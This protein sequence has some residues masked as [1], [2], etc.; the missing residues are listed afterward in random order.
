[1][2]NNPGSKSGAISLRL[3]AAFLFCA[4]A[5]LLAMSGF[6]DIPAAGTLTNKSGPLTYTAGPF[7]VSNK[8]PIIEVDV[9]PRCNGTTLPCDDHAL[10]V[11]LPSGYM[12][13]HPNAAVRVTMSWIDA[14][15]GQ[16]DYDMWVY[17][18][19]D[20]ACNPTDCSST[21]GT[22][23]PIHQSTT[24]ANP[25]VVI[26]NPLHDGTQTY[27]LKI[28]P[29][30]ASGETVTVTMELLPGSGT[31]GVPFG[32]HDKSAPGVPRYQIFEAP[33]GSSAEA[34]S[35]EFNIGF[36]PHSNRIMVMNSSPIWRLT[37]PE[38][39]SPAQPECCEALW[40]DKTPLSEG[41][42]GLDP[43]LWTDQKTGRT[44]ASNSTVGANAVYAYSD[45]DGDNWVEAGFSPPNGGADH[46]TIG[47]GPY[48]A[49]LSAVS[50]PVNQGQAVY[51]C[52]Q[53]V[54]GPAS[55]QRSD[56]LGASYGPGVLVYEGNGIT[57]CHGLHGHI[58]VAPDGAAWLP[59]NQC[60]GVQGGV[61]TTDAG[62][63][64]HE[65]A[66]PNAIS[67]PQGADP[68]IAIDSDSTIY[69]SYVNNQPVAKGSPPE[70]HAHV[71]VGHLD[72][73]SNT[74]TWS[75]DVDLGTSHGIVNAAE[76]E[77]VGGSSGRAAVGFL[78]TNVPGDYQSSEF[79]G[80]WY[81]FIATTYDGGKTWKTI[82]AT[83]NDPVQSMSGIWQQ[84][85]GNEDR[86]LLDFNEIT[87]DAKGRVLYGFSDG[88]VTTG[89]IAGIAP[90]NFV[91]SMRVARQSGGKTLFAS[92]DPTTDTTAAM[93][94]KPPC[95]SGLRYPDVAQLTWKAPDNGGSSIVSY[96]IFRG[97][98]PGNETL[99]GQT[100]NAK[101]TYNDTTVDPAVAH[102]FYVVKAINGVG[103]GPKSDEID[104]TV[105]PRPVVQSPCNVPGVTILTDGAGDSLSP[106]AGTDL[107]SAS[108]AQPYAP[109]GNIK[110]IFTIVTDPDPNFTTAKTPGAAWYLAIKVPDSTQTFGFRYTGV[111]MDA[112]TNGPTFSSYV[113]STNL[114]GG[115]DGRFVDSSKP[116]DPSSNYDP[117]TGTITIVVSASDLQLNPG[118]KIAGFV[119]GSTQTTD[120]GG[121]GTGATEVW[122]GMPDSLAF[123][124]SYT[125]N[126]D[127]SCRPNT[128]PT[129]VLTASPTSGAGQTNVTLDAS[130][131]YDSDTAAPADTISSY[132]FNFGDGS[133]LVT[134][135]T[136]TISHTYSYS[137]LCG[138][139]PCNYP[140]QVTVTDSRGAQ[141][142][143][144][145]QMYV[146]ISAP[147]A[148]PTPT[149]VPTA[150]PTPTPAKAPTI[151][152]AV[153][154]STIKQGGSASFT[155]YT[156]KA[157]SQNLTVPYSMS[158]T[159][160]LGSSY[161]LSGT[162]G[163]VTIKAGKSQAVVNLTAATGATQNQTAILTLQPGSGYQLA[164]P[165]K[166]TVTITP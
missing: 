13:R 148:T 79:P 103:T 86:N 84:G 152:L 19:P 142:V 166:A 33:A 149:P 52:S 46:E 158:G 96:K 83:P 3:L 66:V 74:V 76:I 130:Q 38:L 95:L 117:N 134:Q 73:V 82:N 128:A 101:T 17:P 34:G 60:V 69:Y 90:N 62:M 89:C 75:N 120:V 136:P 155:V 99:I 105:T 58:H 108:L 47:S 93:L 129:A 164:T 107:L 67:Q 97:T 41:F 162:A 71:Q 56:D 112:T 109:D 50:N 80:K 68:S 100:G 94:P 124:G 98:K 143:N 118:D 123:V 104:L 8:T 140:A 132:T 126:S 49:L 44:F 114:S 133:P 153:A 30:T 121:A 22:Q 92:N 161:T 42:I 31:A 21:N 23:T 147:A 156:A 24:S 160:I 77:A 14:G 48:P 122:D 4:A 15:T 20:T 6:A 18:N 51:Y 154:P 70:G 146:S 111:R 85:G 9:G 87:V 113:P 72:A 102:Y 163:Q 28:V 29:S 45:D 16:S 145:A 59:V 144:T 37:P 63:T 26:I 88:C 11:T 12:S 115:T 40:E 138:N 5:A 61:F 35:G 27:T 54:V 2:K 125:V 150:T 55:C 81:A 57:N 78:G 151:N 159:A 116:A 53:D 119:A 32:G 106:E 65:F 131:S 135:S 141:S 137:Q 139:V 36:N 7:F 157:V 91:A 10:T 64:W 110:F 1:M 43:I 25:E 165:N 127:Q 39:L